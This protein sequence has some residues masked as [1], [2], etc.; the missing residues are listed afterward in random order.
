MI[1]VG[2]DDTDTLDSPGTNQLARAI[3]RAAA[4]E[5]QCVRI[6]R[7]QLFFDQRVPYTSKNG[8]ASI[9]LE[10]R[11]AGDLVRLT[12]LCVRVMRDWFVVGSDPGLC[13]TDS[14]PEAVTEFAKLCQRDVVTQAMARELAAAH[15]LRLMGLGGTEGGVIGALAAVGLA[16]TGND[17]RVVQHGEWPEDLSGSVSVQA[18][19]SRDI[20]VEDAETSI[21]IRNGVVDVGK[22]LRP[23]RRAGQ[24][25]LFVRR[26]AMSSEPDS[27]Q[28]LKLT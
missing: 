27:Y 12:D 13:V 3:V 24:T 22:H 9:A 8:S 25:V 5:W 26:D 1:F 11:G 2:I 7:H 28:A 18:V 16:V 20:H 17:G 23:N 10:P 14:V 6:V 15:G 4:D 19:L 21:P